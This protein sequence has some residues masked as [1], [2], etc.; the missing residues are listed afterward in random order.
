MNLEKDRYQYLKM[1]KE[2]GRY[3]IWANSNDY[4]TWTDT[5]KILEFDGKKVKEIASQQY[6]DY[7]GISMTFIKGRTYFFINSDVCR[8]IDG[9]IKVIKTIPGINRGYILGG[10]SENDLFFA[11]PE[12]VAHYNGTDLQ[13]IYKKPA[14]TYIYDMAIFENEIFILADLIQQKSYIIKGILNEEVKA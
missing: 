11:L 5:L 12:G 3:F 1:Y 13:L 14:S 7:S 6:S 2:N 8:Y 9:G 4:S 10:R